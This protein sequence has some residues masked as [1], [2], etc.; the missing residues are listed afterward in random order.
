MLT[1]EN[2]TQ[3]I[4][5]FDKALP[6]VLRPTGFVQRKCACGGSA[7]I[8]DSCADCSAKTLSVASHTGVMQKRLTISQPQDLYEQE[9]DRV[10]E[11]VMQ[12]PAQTGKNLKTSLPTIQRLSTND[13][14]QE[15]VPPIVQE[16]LGSPGQP[17]DQ[18]TRTFIEPRFGH[19]F[20]RVRVHMDA[21]AA[22]SARA[23]N[24]RAYTVGNDLVFGA[25][26]YRPET[27]TGLNLLA[28]E[29]TH[30][31]Q[32]GQVGGST[33]PVI[34]R[35]ETFRTPRVSVRSPVLEEAVTQLT[36]LAPGRP[37]TRDE[38]ALAQGIYGTS[39]DFSR[40]RL[41]PTDVL[42]YRTVANSIRI[43][44][45]FTITDP[46]MAQ[47]FI[48]EL[49]HVWQ[50]QHGGT[51]YLSISLGTQIAAEVGRG[52]RNYAYDYRINPDQSFFDFTPEQQ[53]S[54]VE[55]YFLML[56]DQ[57]N[58]PQHVAA[59]TAHTYQSNHRSGAGGFRDS[60]SATERLAEI[61]R[62][63]PEHERLITQ[64]RA[65]VP[66]PELDIM[67][68][69]AS[70]VMQTPGQDLFPTP[71]ERQIMPVKPLLELRF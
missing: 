14:Q 53:A 60:L 56:R 50:Y 16:V 23:V 24:A 40:V 29:L 71:P 17:L 11:E 47:T 61:S 4:T 45:D 55:S 25:G 5:Q 48:H 35:D 46:Y 33:V 30:T 3:T 49:G 69:R 22:E 9:A 51:S 31:V 20:S 36:E 63:L 19:D 67:R 44:H 28:H 34:Q 13:G 41:L 59:G 38:R 6:S 21:V 52:A 8:T 64:M 2:T 37:L 42:E 32:Q 62:E 18:A 70:E 1:N 57:T 26:Q 58:I 10:A 54:I 39:I 12:T 27:D 7:G 43:P 15:N 65:A 68:I 66:R